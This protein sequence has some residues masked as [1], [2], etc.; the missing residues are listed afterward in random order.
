[1]VIYGSAKVA[2]RKAHT[3]MYLD[4][5]YKSGFLTPTLLMADYAVGNAT[6]L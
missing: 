3:P 5:F 2:G 6:K 4:A 1:M